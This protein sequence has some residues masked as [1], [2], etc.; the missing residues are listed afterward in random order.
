MISLQLA[1]YE[2]PA[3]IDLI[4]DLVDDYARDEMGGGKALS[5]QVR[6]R[7]KDTLPFVERGF[8]VL[9]FRNMQAVGL[10]NCF[11]GF[12]TFLG[13]RMVNIHDL[14]VHHEHRGQGIGEKLL[15]FVEKE[16]RNRGYGKITLEVREDNPAARLYKRFGFVSGEPKMEF[17]SKILD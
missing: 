2:N 10:A 4:I 11:E 6:K 3:D 13:L 12:S 15:A 8:T 7:I 14:A 5:D 9:A 17:L 16:A 1:D